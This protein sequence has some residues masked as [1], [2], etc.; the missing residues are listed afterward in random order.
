LYIN[1]FEIPVSQCLTHYS[2]VRSGDELDIV[3]HKNV[4]LSDV[5]V[6][7]ILDSDCV[8]VL[9]HL[10]NHFR[11]KNLSDSVDKFIDWGWF[12]SLASELISYRIQIMSEEETDKAAGDFTAFIA[13]TY[14]PL[15]SKLTLSDLNTDL[16]HLQS[17][18]KHER[19][20]RKLESN[21]GSSMQIGS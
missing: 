2:P 19:R 11:I 16:P 3:M 7:D 4:R 6:S 15:T 10:L 5:I 13:L 17:L 1:E 9:L 14:R 20:L 18:L 8:T 21:L 12:Q